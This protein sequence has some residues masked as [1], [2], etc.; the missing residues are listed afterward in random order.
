MVPRPKRPKGAEQRNCRGDI[1]KGSAPYNARQ[2]TLRA[3]GWWDPDTSLN[4]RGKRED[5]TKQNE[6]N[7]TK[8]I[9]HDGSKE[10]EGGERG[11]HWKANSKRWAGLKARTSRAH[12]FLSLSR[13]NP[14]YV[15]CREMQ[16]NLLIHTLSQNTLHGGI[17]AAQCIH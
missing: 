16:I 7:R 11:E 5:E 1:S 15:C 2:D 8:K 14:M 3:K 9:R 12:V 6:T 17:H 4:M 10:E 13:I